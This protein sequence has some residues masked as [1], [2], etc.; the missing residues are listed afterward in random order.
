MDVNSK[1]IVDL[2]KNKSAI[3]QDIF[4][5]TQGAFKQLLEL[6]KEQIASYKLKIEDTR[7]RLNVVEKNTTEFHVYIGSDVLVF[8]MHSNVFKLQEQQENWNTPYL[9]EDVTRGYFGI[10]HIYNFLAESFL[11]NRYNDQGYLI[12][13]IMVN[14][15]HHFFME[16]QGQLSF[17]FKDVSKS[18]W[19]AE[20]VKHIIQVSFAYALEFDLGMPPYK[21]VEELTVGQMYSI[22]QGNQVSTGKRLGF[23]FKAEEE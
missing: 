22:G 3:K 4:E 23:K 18:A 20:S 5:G 13:R 10:I 1:Q 21:M 19:T 7:V 14:K 9:K 17:L 2:L 16:G 15:D 6:V 12:G 8:Q 11:Q